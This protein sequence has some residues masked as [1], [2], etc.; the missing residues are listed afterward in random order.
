VV[1]GHETMLPNLKMLKGVGEYNDYGNELP[2]E[3]DYVP[4]VEDDYMPPR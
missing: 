1:Q 3:N 4:E 2:S